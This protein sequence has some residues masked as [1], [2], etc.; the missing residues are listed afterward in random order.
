MKNIL[1]DIRRRPR[2]LR[3][4]ESLRNLIRETTLEPKNL[5]LPLFVVEGKGIKNPI[6]SMPGTFQYSVDQLLKAAKECR[7]L[8]LGGVILFGIPK[9]KDEKAS[10]AYADNGV[11]QM[12]LREL[13]EHVPELFRISDCCLCEYMNHGHCGIVQGKEILNDVSLELLT[14]TAVSQAHAGSQM[15]APSDM[16]D[17]RVLAIRKALDQ[18]QKENIPILSYAV[19]YASAFYGPFRDAAKSIPHFGD[20]KTYQMDPGNFREALQEAKLDLEEGADILMVKPASHYL[21]ILRELKNRLD[22]PLAAY[23]VSGEYSMI[24]AASERGW[25]KE[26]EVMMESL[27]A[28]KRAGAVFILTYFATEAAKI[29]NKG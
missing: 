12:G 29:L 19:K 8:D 1:N 15:I 6:P 5:I 20:R 2:R 24:K 13:A 10:Q 28:I 16:M 27:M 9:H 23:Q 17:G 25:I 18:N 11:V 21:D 14:K 7:S 4:S 3:A 22:C 26:D